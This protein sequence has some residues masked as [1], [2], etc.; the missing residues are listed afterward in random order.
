MAPGLPDQGFSVTSMSMSISVVH[1]KSF[2][3]VRK[4]PGTM[5][6]LAFRIQV[7]YFDGFLV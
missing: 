1:L 5:P 3:F 7:L 2:F 4:L 6:L